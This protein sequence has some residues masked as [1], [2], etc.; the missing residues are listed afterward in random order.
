MYTHVVTLTSCG[1]D[2]SCSVFV[3]SYRL[4][5]VST[6][7]IWLSTEESTFLRFDLLSRHYKSYTT[8]FCQLGFKDTVTF[9]ESP[10]SHST[11]VENYSFETLSIGSH[12]E[13]GLP[14]YSPFSFN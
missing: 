6:L 11:S 9:V 3:F 8:L 1:Q 5:A 2:F 12:L 4:I 10:Y 14:I 7:L 13:D